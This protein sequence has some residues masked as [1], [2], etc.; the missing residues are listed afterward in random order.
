MTIIKNIIIIDCKNGNDHLL[1]NGINGAVDVIHEKEKNIIEK[2]IK[3][4]VIVP[5]DEYEQELYTK[6]KSREYILTQSE[7][8]NR[9]GKI[10]EKMKNKHHNRIESS[11]VWFVLTYGCNFDCPYCYESKIRKNIVITTEMV[12]KVFEI[13]SHIDRIGFFGGEPL[14]PSSK[15]IIEYI[16][17]KAS[18][19]TEYRVITN[20]YYL[21][22]YL[23][24]FKQIKTTNIQVTLDGSEEKHNRTRRLKN[25]DPTYKRIIDGIKQYIYSDIPI[26]VRMN[27]S[28]E[29]VNDCFNEKKKIQST[30]WGAK[31]KFELQ[32]LFQLHRQENTR[33]YNQMFVENSTMRD[34][35]IL[36]RLLPISNFLY[37]GTSLKPIIRACDRDGKSRFYD[38]NGNIYNCI[39]AV[40]DDS[41]S[42][43]NYFPDVALKEKSFMTRDITKIEKCMSCPYALFCGGGCPNGLSGDKD[44]FSPNCTSM[45]N[46]IENTIPLIYKMRQDGK[47]N[48]E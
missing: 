37:N 29:N 27:I 48:D 12:D 18:R 19:D 36:S 45:I 42:I 2:W 26:T 5:C 35:Q 10:I 11:S 25:G 8:T 31:V 9:K 24:I 23:D 22:E 16:I 17:G 15:R 34:N 6:L 32:P 14:L 7:E 39:L 20:G 40:G 28:P 44:I 43:G 3:Y 41:K 13:N 38:P 47:Q 21:K 46:E 33:L 4:N 30:D 1:V